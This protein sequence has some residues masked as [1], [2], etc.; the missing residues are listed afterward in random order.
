MS[1]SRT[2]VQPDIAVR[3]VSLFGL[4]AHSKVAGLVR[5]GTHEN[6]VIIDLVTENLLLD[7]QRNV[8]HLGLEAQFRV[9]IQG[10]EFH[11]AIGKEDLLRWQLFSYLS[12]AQSGSFFPA[13]HR[14][15][16]FQR[17]RRSIHTDS[18]ESQLFPEFLNLPLRFGRHVRIVGMRIV[19]QTVTRLIE[20]HQI[21]DSV[22]IFER[23]IGIDPLCTGI[24][25]YQPRAANPAFE[26]VTI[27]SI[28]PV[29]VVLK[30][31]LWVCAPK[32]QRIV[33]PDGQ[34]IQTGVLSLFPGSLEVE[35]S[36]FQSI[37]RFLDSVVER[38]FPL[39]E[40]QVSQSCPQILIGYRH[41][42]CL[43]SAVNTRQC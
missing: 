42:L 1:T 33:W 5:C 20:G 10:V 9:G 38:L 7:S 41:N 18:R 15:C 31:I 36:P 43:I 22:Y 13:S 6:T 12:P 39:A 35:L 17:I 4:E 26:T 21:V 27:Q 29:H 23:Q 2:L 14:T 24:F 37:G 3:T 28:S 40:A 30:I 8:S 11:I 34:F 16:A 25:V 32:N 19:H